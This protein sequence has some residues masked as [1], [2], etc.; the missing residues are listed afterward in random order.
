VTAD[1][2]DPTRSGELFLQPDNLR[3]MNPE[4]N[5]LLKMAQNGW[6]P[7]SVEGFDFGQN[8]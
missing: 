8:Q 5:P 2:P 1:S 3:K 7:K 6:D 4:E